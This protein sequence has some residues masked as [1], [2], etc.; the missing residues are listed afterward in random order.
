TS[1]VAS[2]TATSCTTRCSWCTWGWRPRGADAPVW[3]RRIS[4]GRRDEHYYDPR[5][6]SAPDSVVRGRGGAGATHGAPRWD[7]HR[8]R[9]DRS[10]HGGDAPAS[11]RCPTRAPHDIVHACPRDGYSCP[12]AW[13]GRRGDSSELYLFLLLQRHCPAR[14]QARIR[15]HPAGHAEPG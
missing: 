7:W 3:V 10:A 1:P 11:L 2:G 15:R 13:S 14:S 9:S 12:R 4:G 6:D 5:L 8:R